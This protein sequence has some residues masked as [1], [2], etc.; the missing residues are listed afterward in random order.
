M[1]KMLANFDLAY[2]WIRP[3]PPFVILRSCKSKLLAVKKTQKNSWNSEKIIQ[4]LAWTFWN[5]YTYIDLLHVWARLDT[6]IILA[7]PRIK[8]GIKSWVKR[9]W[10]M[11]LTCICFSLPSTVM[12]S[13]III[14][15]ALLINISILSPAVCKTSWENFL[16]LDKDDK[17]KANAKMILS[18][19]RI[20]KKSITL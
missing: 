7:D 16:T 10:P 5:F 8:F 17:S 2:A 20:Q 6:L 3:Y 9:K 4:L 1:N 12:V 18:D 11:W 19:K 14:M 15:P 13:S